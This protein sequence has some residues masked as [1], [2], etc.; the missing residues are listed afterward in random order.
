MYIDDATRLRHML[1]AAREA[2]EFVRDKTVD[3]LRNDVVLTR[4]VALTVAT[5]GE[6]AYKVSKNL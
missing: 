6:A 5:I 4:A 3:D 2:V 1:T